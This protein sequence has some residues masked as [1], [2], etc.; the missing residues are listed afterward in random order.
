MPPNRDAD[1]DTCE[2]TSAHLHILPLVP[3]FQWRPRPGVRRYK[4]APRARKPQQLGICRMHPTPSSIGC[5]PNDKST[6]R[7]SV[8]FERKVLNK[9][10]GLKRYST[11][12]TCKTPIDSTFDAPGS[13]TA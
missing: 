2:T 10:H 4:G 12:G 13:E 7:N 8:Y 5:K 9:A 1:G 3:P 11:S 6:V